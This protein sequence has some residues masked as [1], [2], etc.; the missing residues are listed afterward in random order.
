MHNELRSS[1]NSERKDTGQHTVNKHIRDS[2]EG[3]GSDNPH[4]I[5]W[6][7]DQEAGARLIKQLNASKEMSVRKK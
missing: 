4:R 6:T 7:D 3:T 2:P 1:T 5:S